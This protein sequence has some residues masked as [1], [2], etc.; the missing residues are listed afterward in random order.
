MALIGMVNLM[1][2]AQPQDQLSADSPSQL[3]IIVDTWRCTTF[4]HVQTTLYLLQLLDCMLQLMTLL[5]RS[6][7]LLLLSIVSCVVLTLILTYI[8]HT[9]RGVTNLTLTTCYE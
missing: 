9:P 4:L 5:F 6:H 7:K 1:P 2:V 3:M 8:T